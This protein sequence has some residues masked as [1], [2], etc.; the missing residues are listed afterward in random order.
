MRRDLPAGS[1]CDSDD[2]FGWRNCLFVLLNGLIRN[3]QMLSQRLKSD[4]VNCFYER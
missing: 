2:S 1:L 3:A 4:H